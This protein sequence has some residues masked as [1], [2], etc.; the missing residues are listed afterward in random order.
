[1]RLKTAIRSA[2]L[3]AA[4][5]L[6]AIPNAHANRVGDLVEI[7]GAR[8]N[9][10]VGYGV[11]TGLN[12]TGDDVSS[13]LASQSMLSMLRRLGVQSSKQQISLRN[14]AAVIVTATIPPFAKQGTKIDVTV[15]SIGNARSI[16]GGVVIQTLLKGADRKT[17]AVAQGNVVL[18]SFHASGKSG[19]SAKS[20]H[21]TTAR[22]PEGAII[23]R[24][25]PTKFT[26]AGYI[27]LSLRNPSF[28]MAARIA[29]AVGD[30]L[31]NGTAHALDGGTVR[32][33]IP[34]KHKKSPVG[35]IA[36][37]QAIQVA[38]ERRARVVINERTQTIVAG[39]DVRLAPV[40]VVH[41]GLTIVVKERPRVS[42]PV[43]PLGQ[44]NTEVVPDTEVTVEE[45]QA[46]M[47]YLDGAATLSDL[48]RVLGTL[49]LNA[50]ELIS[51]LQALRSAGALEAEVVVQ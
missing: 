32:V 24:E 25:I 21:T 13:P 2:L 31:G 38:S 34:Q 51:V 5:S 14:V 42:Q 30:S 48:A 17:Y 18:G 44:G 23:E 49:G 1:M 16:R 12:G 7:R 29:K 3:L 39:G 36:K 50:R 9:Q 26:E 43:A 37:L 27:E 40:A 4:L 35:L 46:T 20:G 45:K 15:S 11:V 28:T 41:G 6:G 47:Q 8:D 22:I 33:K 10:L 19:S